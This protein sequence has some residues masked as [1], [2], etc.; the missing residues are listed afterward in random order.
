MALSGVR[1]S[2]L[3]LA[4]NCDLCWLASASWRLLSWISSNNRTFSMA[5]AAWSANVVAR[6]ICRSVNGR[7]NRL[8]KSSGRFDQRI[9]YGLQIEGRAADHL[10]HVSGGGLLFQRF[11]QFL[12]AR[13]YLIEQPH[14]LDRDR[15]LVGK[16]FDQLDLL[17]GK[18]LDLEAIDQDHSEEI[19]ALED[20][21]T[22]ECMGIVDVFCA[23]GVFRV[24][25]DV[26]NVD[27]PALQS[28]AGRSAVAT[29]PDRVAVDE[30]LHFI[31]DVVGRRHPQQL[32]IEAEDECPFGL[33]EPHRALA[34]G[35]EDW[36]QIE[37]RA[38]DHFEHV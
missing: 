32:A 3:M 7:T 21:H 12:G 11:A 22:E 2:W 6:S 8:A 38:T 27:G 26:V 25:L 10:E 18:R 31:R 16:G 15:G 1:S 20:R 29:G 13:F 19:I 9:E 4:R 28:S 17:V 37:S 36:L 30:C 23:I 14:V 33:A 34:H 35:F 24:S 5:M